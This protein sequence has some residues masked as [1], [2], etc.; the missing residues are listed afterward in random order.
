MGFVTLEQYR[1]KMVDGN[2]KNK[3]IYHSGSENE[4]HTKAEKRS[5]QVWVP[6]K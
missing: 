6:K 4:D 2:N 3:N 5:Q 1:K